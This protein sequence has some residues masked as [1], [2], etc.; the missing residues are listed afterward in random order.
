[1]WLI[2]LAGST[3]TAATATP[4]SYPYLAGQLLAQGTLLTSYS[5][6]DAYELAGDATLLPGGVGASLDVIFE[7]ACAGAP[8]S[9]ASPACPESSQ[10]SPAEADAFLQR[11]AGPILS[12]P[13]YRENGLVLISF[14]PAS[15]SAGSPA[16][17]LALQPTAGALL[18]SPLLHGGARSATP[19][20]S[21]SPRTS[22]AAIFKH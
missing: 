4:A 13:A 3:F 18:L 8:T 7:P 6:L 20:N 10:P 12:S 11:V 19:F 17:T 5:A 2:T 16:T 1:V 9:P 22:V 14:A 21:L 15:S